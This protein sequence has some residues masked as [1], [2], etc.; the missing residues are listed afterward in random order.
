MTQ[1]KKRFI[2]IDIGTKFGGLT[3]TGGAITK[4]S[5]NSKNQKTF[6]ALFPCECKCGNTMFITGSAL[7][8]GKR[9]R[10]PN[11][12]YKERPQS[13]MSLSNLERAYN[14]HIVSRCK[15]TKIENNLSVED[16]G[17]LISKNCYYCNE[18]PKVIPHLNHN[19]IALR[20]DFYM[21]GVD[22][23]DSSKSYQIDNCVPCCKTCNMSKAQMSVD[24]FK[25]HITKI[26]N[27]ICKKQEDTIKEK[28]DLN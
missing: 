25:N 15:R 9:T 12:A 3:V 8:S 22:R 10:C 11:C 24:E 5:K 26:Y 27:Y 13:T 17:T 16:Y 28:Q 21:N 23:V 14:L 7:R 1:N 18:P 2:P 4:I 19:R 20:E 6:R